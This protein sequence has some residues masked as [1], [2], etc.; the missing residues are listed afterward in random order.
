[1]WIIENNGLRLSFSLMGPQYELVLLGGQISWD[2][3]QNNHCNF[4]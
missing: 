1:M 3:K 2:E 4:S